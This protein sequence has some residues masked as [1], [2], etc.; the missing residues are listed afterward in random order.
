ML[1]TYVC[2]FQYTCI[3]AM[4]YYPANAMPVCTLMDTEFAVI[5]S[6]SQ[7]GDTYLGDGAT[8]LH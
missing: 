8:D 3:Y 7:S 5:P 2:I 6:F 4:H 1:N